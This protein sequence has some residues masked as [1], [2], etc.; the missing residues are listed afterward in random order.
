VLRAQENKLSASQVAG[1]GESTGRRSL[2]E[3][4]S[5][6]RQSATGKP[7][8]GSFEAQTREDEGDPRFFQRQMQQRR[9][10]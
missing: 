1:A 4:P 10:Q 8:R 6:Y 5:A 9:N 7:I 2:T 3:P